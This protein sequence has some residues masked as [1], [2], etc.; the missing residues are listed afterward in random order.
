MNQ[1]NAPSVGATSLRPVKLWKL[2]ILRGDRW[3]PVGACGDRPLAE[4]QI[5]TLR[6]LM[7]RN[8]FVLAWEGEGHGAA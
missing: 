4:A 5:A 6:K 7:P 8:Q 2:Y 1:P 3:V